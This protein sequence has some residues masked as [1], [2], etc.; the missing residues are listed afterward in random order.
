MTN[1]FEDENG[2]YFVLCNEEGQHSLWPD[3]ADVPE[4]WTKRFGPESRSTCL[5]FVEKNW[6]DMRPASLAREMADEATK[7][8]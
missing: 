4:G 2:S 7:M 6:T 1:P 3:F 5:A 8:Q